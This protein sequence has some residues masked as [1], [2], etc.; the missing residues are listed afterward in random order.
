MYDHTQRSLSAFSCVG[1]INCKEKVNE[2]EVKVA[3]MIMDYENGNF[4][5]LELLELIDNIERLGLGRHFQTNITRVLN[6]I[7]GLDENNLGLK[8]E[9]DNL[10]AVALKFRILR[11]HGNYVSQGINFF[12]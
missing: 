5:S 10:H 7:A 1:Q 4:S 12:N 9:E 8:Q 3:S 2:L 11:K 6:K